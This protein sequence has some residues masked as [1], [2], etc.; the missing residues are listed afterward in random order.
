M[1]KTLFFWRPLAFFP[2]WRSS[3]WYVFYRSKCTFHFFSFL[4]FFEKAIKKKNE[5]LAGQKKHKMTSWG[6]QNEPKIMEKW[7]NKWYKS[8]KLP[9]KSVFREVN[10][11]IIFWMAKKSKKDVVEAA[12]VHL[13]LYFCFT[14]A[15]LLLIA[16]P[17]Y[18]CSSRNIGGF[19]GSSR[20]LEEFEG[21][22]IFSIK[23]IRGVDLRTRSVS[24]RAPR[25]N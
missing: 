1:G 7:S 17:Q 16:P 4:S 25:K 24:N 23:Q 2:T 20:T 13:V 6:T 12:G 14:F 3:R 10:S 19:E 15:L 8:Q 11:L 9:K 22:A 5:K 18:R 21:N